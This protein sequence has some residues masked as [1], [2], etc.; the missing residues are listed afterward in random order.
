MKINI[1]KFQL[2]KPSIP[3]GFRTS[4]LSGI[5]IH[6]FVING[7]FKQGQFIEFFEDENEFF[8]DDFQLSEKWGS[9]K[10]NEKTVHK[11][12]VCAIENFTLTMKKKKKG[13]S[14]YVEL[15]LQIGD[16]FF[17][18]DDLIELVARNEGFQSVGE[19]VSHFLHESRKRRKEIL[20]GQVVH[21]TNQNY[22]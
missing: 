9:E 19:F 10:V 18:T 2:F 21:W 22:N 3:S 13:S 6:H 14:S 12:T 16:L 15:T 11:P 20:I 8:L 1:N 17:D 5:K 7:K 4:I